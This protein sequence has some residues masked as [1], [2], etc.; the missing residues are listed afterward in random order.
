MLPLFCRI[1]LWSTG[2]R[3]EVQKIR[4][5]LYMLRPNCARRN[6]ILVPIF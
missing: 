2:L 6:K 3:T 5:S 4:L 1:A